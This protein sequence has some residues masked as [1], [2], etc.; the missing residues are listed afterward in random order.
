MC[1]DV[2]RSTWTVL[3]FF[4]FVRGRKEG[5]KKRGEY[6]V[7]REGKSAFKKKKK[8]LIRNGMR[9]QKK[10]TNNNNAYIF[11]ENQEREFCRNFQKKRKKKKEKNYATR[12]CRNKFSALAGTIIRVR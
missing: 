10:S 11:N 3:S 8:K 7:E 4:F 1:G 2:E 5:E 12:E 9:R 6:K